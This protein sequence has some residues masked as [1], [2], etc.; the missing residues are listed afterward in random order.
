MKPLDRIIWVLH[1]YY[2]HSSIVLGSEK[3]EPYSAGAAL[4]VEL[5]L[6]EPGH[7]PSVEP[8]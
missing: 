6:G 7:V 3:Y 8:C 5:G 1:A 2:H 4:V